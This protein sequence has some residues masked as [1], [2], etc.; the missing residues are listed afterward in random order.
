ML[1]PFLNEML[2]VGSANSNNWVS[3]YTRT[4][5]CDYPRYLLFQ[6]PVTLHVHTLHLHW[7]AGKQLK[8]LKQDF[9]TDCS[10]L[11]PPP[12]NSQSNKFYPKITPSLSLRHPCSSRYA[13]FN[14]SALTSLIH[15]VVCSN[16]TLTCSYLGS[17]AKKQEWIGYLLSFQHFCSQDPDLAALCLTLAACSLSACMP[18]RDRVKRCR[19]TTPSQKQILFWNDKDV[20]N[21]PIWII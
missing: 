18:A 1:I 14:I 4:S 3:G 21:G 15:S 6:M 13:V 10:S 8:Y 17:R 5:A 16:R 19:K 2:S 11:P 20:W 12:Q 7:W 9:V